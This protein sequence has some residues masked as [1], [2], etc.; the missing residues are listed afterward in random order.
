MA[1]FNQ[2]QGIVTSASENDLKGVLKLKI[3]GTSEPLTISC[4]SLAA[5]DEMAELIDGYCRLVN[6]SKQSCWNRTGMCVIKL[7]L[8][9]K[10]THTNLH[11]KWIQILYFALKWIVF[12]IFFPGSET[13]DS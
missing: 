2:V 6:S 11:I 9:I 3:S 5:A 10:G 4:P 1:D 7:V 12:Q 8:Y 13:D